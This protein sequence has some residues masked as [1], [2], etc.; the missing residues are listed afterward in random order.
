[1][2][3]ATTFGDSEQPA[4]SISTGLTQSHS[5]RTSLFTGLHNRHNCLIRYSAADI[6]PLFPFQHNPQLCVDFKNTDRTKAHVE[7]HVKH[8]PIPT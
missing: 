6:S 1:M 5:L 4:V 2:Y 7:K 8:K 3:L